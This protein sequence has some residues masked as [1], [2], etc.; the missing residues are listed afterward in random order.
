MHCLE[1]GVRCC[2]SYILG[3]LENADVLGRAYDIHG[4]LTLNTFRSY[5]LVYR[6]SLF[7]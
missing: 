1:S 5:E 3:R 7:V 2:D 6:G 4:H